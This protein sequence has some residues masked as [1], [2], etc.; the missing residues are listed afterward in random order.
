VTDVILDLPVSERTLSALAAEPLMLIGSDWVPAASGESLGVIDPATEL[1]VARLAAGDVEDVDRAVRVARAAFESGAWR[2]LPPGRQSRLMYQL[3]DAM[4][5]DVQLLSELEAIDSGK[6]FALAQ[7]EVLQAAEFLRYYAGWPTKIYGTVNPVGSDVLSYTMR[8][9]I[10]VVT[11]IAPWNCPLINA[12]YKVAPALACGN[13]VI[14]KPAEQTSLT[15]LRFG[16]LCLD[17]GIPAGVVQ[18][19][20]GYGETVG[21]A[22]V[23]HPDVDKIAFTGSTETGRLIARRGADRLK[24]ISLELG[25]KSPGIIFADADLKAA[26]ELLFSPYG[27]WYNSGQICVQASRLLVQREIQDEF[28][29]AVV[30]RSRTLKMGSPFDEGTELG[31]LVSSDQLDRVLGYLKIAD[32]EG[33]EVQLGG[34]RLNRPGYFVEPTVLCGMRPEMRI[35]QEEIF[36]PVVGVIPFDTDDE[37]V[38]LAN[39]TDFGLAASVWTSDIKRGH[40]MAK[41]LKSGVV[42]I[43]SFADTDSSVAFGGTKQSGYGRECGEE[44]IHTYTQTKS[45]YCRL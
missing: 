4:D 42:W 18:V 17:V 23:V 45:V 38:A 43:N 24:K 39:G 11:G 37:V 14:L 36:G 8:E 41:R 5:A 21:D 16:Q 35:A 19:L 28:V 32:D 1:E 15:S 33:V 9:P 2:E 34:S 3:A 44:S 40:T 27:V 31:P 10:G 13:S 6:P 22:L 26:V 29:A 30:A 20:T 25:G 12:V 7:Q